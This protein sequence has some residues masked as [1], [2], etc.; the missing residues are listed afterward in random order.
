MRYP[1]KDAHGRKRTP[2]AIH[3]EGPWDLPGHG[4]GLVYL[5]LKEYKRQMNAPDSLW[6]CPLCRYSADWDDGNYERPMGV[7]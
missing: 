3:C 2:W 6:K 7:K 4:H 5:T 1:L